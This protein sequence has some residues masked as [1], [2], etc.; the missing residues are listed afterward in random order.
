MTGLTGIPCLFSAFS[1]RAWRLGGSMAP[2]SILRVER[3]KR[4]DFMRKRTAL[5]SIALWLRW[6]GQ[7]RRADDPSKPITHA[8]LATGGETYI[9][10]GTGRVVW[11][12]P[13]ASRDGWVLHDGHVL[14]ALNKSQ[15][16]PGGAAVE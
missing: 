8:F 13:H 15:T 12:Y 1:W 2:D 9:M 11:R 7:D 4:T 5:I 16:Y 14:L 10:D 6:L 3:P